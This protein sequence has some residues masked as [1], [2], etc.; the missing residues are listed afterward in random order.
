MDIDKAGTLSAGKIW[1]WDAEQGRF[2]S[3][4]KSAKDVVVELGNRRFEGF[5][6]GDA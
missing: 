1:L 4:A 3:V 6:G 2:V 5:C